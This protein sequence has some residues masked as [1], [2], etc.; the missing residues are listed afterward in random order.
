MAKRAIPEINA[1]SMADIAFLLLIFFLVTTTMD[2]DSGIARKLPEKIDDTPIIDFHARNVFIVSLRDNDILVEG[3]IYMSLEEL[4]EATIAFLDNG[5]GTFKGEICDY[6]KGKKD[7]TSSD[8]PKEAIVS[9][10]STRSTNYGAYIAVQNEL[11]AAYNYLRNRTANEL[12]GVSLDELV[13]KAKDETNSNQK[14]EVLKNKIKKIKGMYPM[15][16]SEA[17]PA[18]F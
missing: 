3:N 11:V 4:K 17:E 1:G 7:L 15:I 9:I 10:E 14:T 13:K 2:I 12:Y 6:C 16:I 18:K 5:G 8:H